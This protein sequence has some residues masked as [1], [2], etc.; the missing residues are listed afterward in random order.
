[1][2]DK[3]DQIHAHEILD[4]RGNPTV[5]VSLLTHRGVI[6]SASVPSGA[7]T[8]SHEAM[9]LRDGDPKRY[10]G[11][12]VKKAC[13]NINLVLAPKL[14]GMRVTDQRAIDELMIQLDGTVNKKR[15]GANAILGVSLAAAHAA[16]RSKQMPLYSYLRWTFDLTEETWRMPI[17][18][19]NILNGG[20]HADTNLDIQEFIIAPTGIRKFRERVR[21]GAE[22]FHALG[23]ILHANGLDTDVGNEGG[24]APSLGKTEDALVYI[25]QAIK[26]AGYVPG[27]QI[28]LGLD[29]AANEFYDAKKDRYIMR[30]DK[31]KMT[32]EQMMDLIADWVDRYPFVSI[33][34]GLQE[35]KW[36]E[37]AEL[38]RRLGKRV[39]LIGDDLF[40]TNVKRL[41][42]GIERKVAN[43]ILIKFNQ[44]GTLS[45]T[46]N[47][48]ALAKAHKYK[49]VIS[50]RSGETSDTTLAD[51]AVAVN[52]DFVKTGAPSRSERLVKY[53]RLMEIEEEI[54]R[55]P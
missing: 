7:S 32:D 44:I 35:D 10:G 49:V 4:S 3:I 51:L 9:E 28:R 38:T 53:N 6:G 46:M 37:W 24:Y 14:R 29:V 33:E 41:Q 5:A 36:A 50:H 47:T 8:G 11:K 40:V 54:L 19:M 17:P 55:R 52:A 1:M 23:D 18:L 16:A 43:T 26:K 22:I 13:R 48:I 31:R 34:D 25:M 45:E 2:S 15:L 42:E 21:A 30:T 39:Y 20:S 12:G 27:K